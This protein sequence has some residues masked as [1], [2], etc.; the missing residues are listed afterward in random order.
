MILDVVPRARSGAQSRAQSE[1]ILRALVLSPLSANELITHLNLQSK[2]GAFKRAIKA[3]LEKK[4]IAYT[5]PDKPSS[6]L[7]KYQLTRKGQT[8]LTEA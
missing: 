3:L 5:V 4:L 1:S 8:Y 6:R 7:Q 2:T